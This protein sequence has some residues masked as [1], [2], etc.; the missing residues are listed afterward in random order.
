MKC[1]VLP[2]NLCDGSWWSW[3]QQASLLGPLW[4]PGT[5]VW[6]TF[7]NKSSIYIINGVTEY[8]LHIQKFKDWNGIYTSGIWF[9]SSLLS[10]HPP[11]SFFHMIVLFFSYL[12]F[13]IFCHLI[14][15]SLL[16]WKLYTLLLFFFFKATLEI[17]T[18]VFHIGISQSISLL[19]YQLTQDPSYTLFH[20]PS[21]G[22]AIF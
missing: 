22:L 7:R 1:V 10:F 8:D 11:W 3:L 13:D 9:I 15:S 16:V 12:L 2:F 20:L 6:V 4:P 14:Y 17:T 21:S 19:S 5:L 18:W